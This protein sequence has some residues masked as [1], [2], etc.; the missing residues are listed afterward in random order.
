M[1]DLENITLADLLPDSIAKDKKVDASAKAIDPQLK[2][3]TLALDLP[4]LYVSIDKLSSTQ[5]D[6]LATQYDVS[7]WRDSWPID[8]KR[9]AL[10]ASIADKRKKGTLGAVK[11][12]I[13]SIGSAG[14]VTEWW[15]EEPK[16]TPHTFRIY[17]TQ[18]QHEGVIDDELQE[19]LIALIDDAKP[20]RSH[21]N[22]VIQHL[23][24]S[25]M[26]ACAFIR[27]ATYAK[28]YDDG[29]EVQEIVSSIGV[30]VAMRAVTRRHL[31]MSAE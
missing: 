18:A 23:L 25:G 2:L 16:G 4:A 14:T 1:K 17:A 21:Y 15:Q 5:L 19:D 12:A 27:T 24:Q 11:R 10:K 6:H 8:L 13:A 29:R 31:I 9:S 30:N 20:L 3:M 22:F 26:N 7:V 28:I